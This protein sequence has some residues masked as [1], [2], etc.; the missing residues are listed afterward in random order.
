MQL[1]FL[2]KPLL[3]AFVL[4]AQQ[5]MAQFALRIEDCYEKAKQNYPLIKQKELVAKSTE[6]TIGNA[7]SA[8][9]PQFTLSAQATYQSDVT[10]IPI[11]FP[12]VDIKP[13]SKDQYKIV[14]EVNQTIFD[15]GNIK[16]QVAVQTASA[17]IEQQ[18]LEVEL[19]KIKDRINQ[20]FFGILLMDAQLAQIELLKK[21]L[22]TSLAK[23]ESAIRNGIAFKSNADILQAELLKA[24]QRVIEMK[25]AR[26]AYLD[27][28]GYFI[29]QPLNESTALER[30]ATIVADQT[31]SV[32]RPELTLYQF[33]NELLGAQ[34]KANNTRNMPRLG[35]FVQGGYGRPALNALKN[36]F[37]FYYIGG[38]RLNWSLGGLYNAHRDRQLL[39]VNAQGID[40]QK[41]VFLFNT[42]IA[43]K[44]QSKE[45]QKLTDLIKVDE[46]IISL[47][48]RIKA[49]AQAQHENGVISTNDLLRELNAEDTAKQN[50]LLHE[51]Q[52]L[53]AQYNYQSTQGN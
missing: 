35:A 30:P 44:Q 10:Q 36:E 53:L 11:S 12:G 3:F 40:S 1:K 20:I 27:M 32:K 48:T 45:L 19:Y 29:N 14:G 16:S 28:L 18:K 23:T 47:R 2:F 46:Q 5:S 15:G 7:Q 4:F 50:L 42:N 13:L 26:S 38:L 22:Q 51:V 34:F 37:D 9:L 43:L 31:I 33:Q 25:A 49:T 41:E 17:Q 21:D 8:H 52:L 39:D 24:D 6:Y